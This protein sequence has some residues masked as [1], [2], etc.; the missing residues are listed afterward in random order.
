MNDLLATALDA[1]KAASGILQDHFGRAD[2]GVEAKQ[3]NDFVTAADRASERCILDC[4]RQ[5][6]PDHA[7]LSEEDGWSGVRGAE[8]VWV[9]DPLDGTTNFLHGLPVWAVSIGCLRDRRPVLGVIAEPM[10]G[11]V[12]RAV[13]GDGA[14]CGDE[15]LRVSQ[16]QGLESAF[17]ATGFPF[18]AKA[19]LG[20]YLQ[21]F[22]AA[23]RVARAIRRTGAAAIDLAYTAQGTYDGFFEF[24]LS[25]WDLAAGTV[26][27][28][29]AGGRVSDLDGDSDFLDSG[30]VLA[31]APGAWEGLVGILAALGGE[32][33]LARRL[34]S[35]GPL[36]DNDEHAQR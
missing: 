6:H 28:E 24:L 10:T 35:G 8:F 26:L 19:A 25:P 14:Y 31:G 30:S 15:R 20:L 22:E 18:K 33:E 1:A 32:A 17:L 16:R 13:S 34:H 2:L 23:F 29:E 36:P 12:F 5:R 27:I 7:I 11:K 21:V 3:A 9:V 4:I